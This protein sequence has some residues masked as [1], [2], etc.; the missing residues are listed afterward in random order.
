MFSP[1]YFM[2]VILKQNVSSLGR[3][4]E[5][6]NVKDGY[7]QNYLFPRG[8]AEIATP[9]KMKE[10]EFSKSQE[11]THKELNIEKAREIQEQLKKV[12]I[13]LKAKARGDRLYGSISEKEIV[14]ALQEKAHLGLEKRHLSISEPI[15][16]VGTYEIPVRL[17]EGVEGKLHLEV[18]PE[19]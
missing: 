16:V 15:K 9:A 10:A 6:K 3:K 17:F 5:V 14:D 11:I 13:V 7:F 12:K 8:L 1:S 19:K 2:Q 18:K 4:G